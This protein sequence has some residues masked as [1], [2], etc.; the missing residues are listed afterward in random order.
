M[1]QVLDGQSTIS[2]CMIV[3]NEERYISQCLTSVKSFV[4]Q[5][6]VVDTVQPI[7]RVNWRGSSAPK[8]SSIPGRGDFSQARNYSISHATGD[9]ILILDAD[10]ALAESDAGRLHKLVGEC[11]VDGLKLTQR[12]Y[13]QNANFV[14]ATPNPRDYAEGSEYSDCVNVSVIRLFRNDPGFRYVG[15]VHELVE[16]SFLSE[17][18]A[19]RTPASSFTIS[20][21]SVIL[22]IWSGRNVSISTLDVRRWWISRRMRWRTSSWESNITNSNNIRTASAPFR[23]RSN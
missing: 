1:R 3:R 4:D 13:L 12:T 15:R 22:R 20:G 7:R 19:T 11:R 10:E 18:L 14:C 2:L 5:I 23:P 6:V 17:H 8:S 9:W 21:R 16:P